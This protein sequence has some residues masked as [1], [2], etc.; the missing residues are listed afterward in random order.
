MA[1]E[2]G[3]LDD[4]GEPNPDF[5]PTSMQLALSERAG[6]GTV[7]TVVVGFVDAESMQWYLLDMDIAEQM[8][9]TFGQIDALL[10][11]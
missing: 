8:R 10:V 11:G 5:T 2:D 1:W 4:R 7:M 3:F 6:G 9:Q